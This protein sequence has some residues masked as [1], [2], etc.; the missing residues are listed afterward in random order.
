MPWTVRAAPEAAAPFHEQ[1]Y[2]A[3]SRKLL[4]FFVVLLVLTPAGAD[5][6]KKTD[7]PSDLKVTVEVPGEAPRLADVNSGRYALQLKLQNTGKEPLVVWP[8]ATAELFNAEGKPVDPDRMLGRSGV[9]FDKKSILEG[10]TFVTLKP[11]E[12]HLLNFSLSN[13]PFDPAMIVGWKVPAP[14]EYRVAIRYKYDRKTV[15]EEYGKGC[16]DID[17]AEKP[18]NRACEMDQKVEA[19]FKILP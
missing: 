1:E 5:D 11:G 19:K 18:W 13:F 2:T 10:F 12:T 6:S 8:Y 17:N 16:K 14:G 3:M 7:E 15:K 4:A 9:R